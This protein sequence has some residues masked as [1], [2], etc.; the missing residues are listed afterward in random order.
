MGPS[1]LP[2][3]V[4]KPIGLFELVLKRRGA[5]ASRG[6]VGGRMGSKWLRASVARQPMPEQTSAYR[7]GRFELAPVGRALLAD[8][9]PLKVGGRAF[10]LLLALVER[11]E[12]TVS[13]DELF[14]LVWPGRVVE[15]QNLKTQVLALRKVLGA[16]AIATVPGRGY[17]FAMPLDEGKAAPTDPAPAAPR[18]ARTAQDNLPAE[19]PTLHGRVADIGAVCALVAEQRL[20]TLAGAGGIGKTRLAQAVA[21]QMRP[22]FAGGVWIVELAPLRASVELIGNAVLR[23]LGIADAPAPCTPDAVVRA[24]A[25]LELL[26]VLDNCEHLVGEASALAQA[27]LE[28]ASKVHLLATSQEPLHIGAEK[29]YRLG[30]LALPPPAAPAALD[31]ASVSLLIERARAADRRFELRDDNAAAVAEICRRLDG[32]PLAIELAAARVPLLGAAGVRDRLDER[33][34][35]LTAG[36]RNAPQRQQT[37]RDTLAWS[38]ALLSSDEQRVFRRLA[39]FSGGFSL[40][41][42]QQVGADAVLDGWGVLDAL[43][44]L[45]DRSLVVAEGDGEPRYRLFES[46]REFALHELQRSG[47]A[48]EVRRAHARALLALFDSADAV[49]FIEPTLPW[50]ARLEPEMPN[51]REA[52][53][54]SLSPEGEPASAI[55]IAVCVA[56]F[57]MSSGRGAEGLRALRRIAA[58]LDAHAS[59]SWRARAWLALGEL[60]GARV[61]SGPEALDAAQRAAEG[62]RAT[63]DR[64]RLYRALAIVSRLSGDE[65]D[66][67]LTEAADHEMAAIESPDWPL[68]LTRLRR[69]GVARQLRRERRL[70]ECRDAFEAEART[71]DAAGDNYRAWIEWHNTAL[72]EMMLGR[73]EHALRIMADV[74]G[75]IRMRGLTRALW[76]QVAMHALAMIETETVDAA[77][78]REAVAVLRMQNAL[79]WLADHLAWLPAQRGRFDDAARLHG[80][81]EASAAARAAARGPVMQAARDRLR[82][83][84]EA[85]LDAAVL[86]RLLRDGAALDE[87][88]V[89]ALALGEAG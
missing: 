19:L 67:A 79:W 27:L 53:A 86:E 82:E 16:Q 30:A 28:G 57:A 77:A 76:Q 10:D 1:Q 40:P 31:F 20:V 44:A 69:V 73:C 4:V 47:E 54:F 63:P 72:T 7:F 80:W 33:L 49:F 62:L 70:V 45:V 39:V 32:N 29:V 78:L 65:R 23:V 89:A 25:A 88:R 64:V 85:R 18:T 68:L 34:R 2:W 81:A 37:L 12:R 48:H 75:A 15:D 83:H 13:R 26:L 17:R 9:E 38:H 59:P 35:L 6:L 50:L 61:V 5:A 74:V 66:R 52:F 43:G 3:V 60:C 51:A 14:D 21:H 58:L 55:G 41:L 71:S 24:L 36:A 46:A 11:R 42:A 87:A 56:A 84:L 8:G 22:R